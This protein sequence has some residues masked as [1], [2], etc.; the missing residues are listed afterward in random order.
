MKTTLLSRFFLVAFLSS[1]PYAF[2]QNAF[3]ATAMEATQLGTRAELSQEISVLRQ[4]QMGLKAEIE[5]YGQDA[6]RI[7]RE[8]ELAEKTQK[9]SAASIAS[10]NASINALSTQEKALA[11]KVAA[12]NERDGNL[13]VRVR[14]LT[15]ELD[16]LQTR[17][18]QEKN[19][20]DTITSGNAKE[21]VR[22]S[23]ELETAKV[24]HASS[25]SELSKT[26]Q[27]VQAKRAVQEQNE[28]KA[29]DEALGAKK[30]ELAALDA[31]SSAVR[32]EQNRKA[33]DDIAQ[34]KQTAERE[35]DERVARSKAEASSLAAKT[36]AEREALLQAA[37]AEVAARTNK[38]ANDEKA[39]EQA[40]QAAAKQEE[41]ELA[42]RRSAVTKQLDALEAD[43]A[44][45][46]KDT[47]VQIAAIREKMLKDAQDEVNKTKEQNLSQGS[48]KSAALNKQLRDA[49]SKVKDA[50]AKSKDA[51]TK[52]K[53]AEAR[54]QQASAKL[55]QLAAQTQTLEVRQAQLKSQPQQ[56]A[57]VA[58]TLPPS[59]AAALAQK[60]ALEQE[61][62][63]MRRQLDGLKAD[64]LAKQIRQNMT[65]DKK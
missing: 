28:V 32:E 26:Q 24:A 40:R 57:P 25:M 17:I 29:L 55:A 19:T 5:R 21:V 53:T 50:E 60:A 56:A 49:E 10:L 31:K 2:G 8:L 42:K 51:E 14:T 37:Q 38:L 12:G 39:A 61:I 52:A 45:E 3:P 27:E 34:R 63:Q 46:K 62:L 54:E 44:Q 13:T 47:A 64:D 59:N 35:A 1:I 16:S 33:N 18:A 11:S 48:D 20:L 7:K 4:Q 23:K 9:E 30:I 22:L 36:Q 43:A 6:I 41:E 58:Q 15:Q 65:P